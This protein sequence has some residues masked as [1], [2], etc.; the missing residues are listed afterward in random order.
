MTG[1]RLQ[2]N[3]PKHFGGSNRTIIKQA[4]EMIV[5][6]R[7]KLGNADIGALVTLDKVYEL[8]EGNISSEK[9]KDILDIHQRFTQDKDYPG[10]AARVAKALCLMEFVRDL[11]RT[12]RNIAALLLERVGDT[13]QTLAVEAVLKRLKEAQFVRESDEGWKLQTAQEKNWEQEKRSYASVKRSERNEI[14]RERVKDIFEA[15]KGRQYSYRGLR[16]FSLG[17]NLDG[18]PVQPGQVDL[19]LISADQSEDWIRRRAE[20]E[21]ESRK[22]AN[23]DRLLWLFPVPGPAEALI[24]DFFASQKMIDR[25]THLSGQQ[26]IT[27]LETQTLSRSLKSLAYISRKDTSMTTRLR[28]SEPS[29]WRLCR[30][31]GKHTSKSGFKRRMRCP[32]AYY[33]S[34]DT[35]RHVLQ[36]ATFVGRHREL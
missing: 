8:V 1:I 32:D 29:E 18:Q 26:S 24:E 36:T 4:Y 14:L 23:Q 35:C 19:D 12:P 16:Q 33:L 17:L 3:A 25:Y 11:P 31:V 27:D 10:V 9:Q 28:Y 6:D 20:V 34:S 5:S 21:S 22:D 7:T 2:P 15:S 30:K 13:A